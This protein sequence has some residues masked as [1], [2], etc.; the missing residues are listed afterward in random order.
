MSIMPVSGQLFLPIMA[1]VVAKKPTSSSGSGVTSDLKMHLDASN[2]SS[3]TGSSTSWLDLSGNSNNGTLYSGSSVGIGPAYNNQ[4]QGVLA[5]NGSTDYVNF[6]GGLPVTDNLTYEA[7]V[8]P[9]DLTG[10]FK[11]ILNHDGW[12]TGYVH[13]QF[14]GTSLQFALNGESDKY[15]TFSFST[16]TWYQVAAVYSK[17]AKTISFYVNGSFTNT[18]TYVNPPSVT[19]TGF[20]MGSWDGSE[21][22]FSGKMGLVRIY[23]RALS[24]SE[25]QTNFNGSK[26][27]FGL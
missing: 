8:N 3:Y 17:S 5:F 15:S 1:G 26:S 25:I 7:W 27:R 24:S 9:S 18:E 12:S 10:D 4:D 14:G 19:T 13:F 22:F 21:R 20:K 16:N 11:V 6:A 23:H 2:S